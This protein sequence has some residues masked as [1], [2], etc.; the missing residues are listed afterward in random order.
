MIRPDPHA[1]LAHDFATIRQLIYEPQFGFPKPSGVCVNMMPI[2]MSWDYWDGRRN[3]TVPE[4]LAG[5]LDLIFYCCLSQAMGR[6]EHD[7]A[8]LTVHESW[9]A[10]GA[11]QRR[12]GV[13][14]ERPCGGRVV[15]DD[16]D[17]WYDLK[18]GAG[19]WVKSLDTAGATVTCEDGCAYEGL[20]MASSVSGMGEIWPCIV[21]E[22]GRVCDRHGGLEH[23]RHQLG[24][25]RPILADTLYWLTDR[26]PHAS[27][28]N[29]STVPVYRQFFRL[30][31][32]PIDRWFSRHNTP[33][34]CGLAPAA[35]ISD[36]DKF[37]QAA[38][39]K[40]AR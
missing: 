30:V 16:E 40:T 32:G 9:V 4:S 28:P 20:F 17:A 3:A 15:G 37:D 36:E 1:F 23:V 14:V 39:D 24:E 33:N 11:C 6:G 5:Y 38:D 29:L 26:T 31:V 19:A 12:P 2:G 25:S 18:W 13:H 10:P 21:E 34:P 27:L 7:V 8:Y 22:P 35:A